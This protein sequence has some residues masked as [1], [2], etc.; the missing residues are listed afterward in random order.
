MRGSRKR[1]LRGRAA[2]GSMGRNPLSD[3]DIYPHAVA[4]RPFALRRRRPRGLAPG[5]PARLAALSTATRLA[6]RRMGLQVRLRWLDE[7]AQDVRYAL[8][9]LRNAPGFTVTAVLMLALGI[10]ANSAIFSI[11]DGV[12]IRPLPYEDPSRVVRLLPQHV[13]YGE[14]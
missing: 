2:E 7:L 14:S 8:R 13:Q 4:G 5:R 12:L 11:V 1:A 9:T 3:S 6:E 10:G